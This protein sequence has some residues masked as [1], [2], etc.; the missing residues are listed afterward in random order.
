MCN[1][2]KWSKYWYST[3]PS[4]L[5]TCYF[6]KQ[7]QT[8]LSKQVLLGIVFGVVVVVGLGLGIGL[9]VGKSDSSSDEPENIPEKSISRSCF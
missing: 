6:Y 5:K 3:E 4:I 8:M 1:V 2:N 7:I 9:T